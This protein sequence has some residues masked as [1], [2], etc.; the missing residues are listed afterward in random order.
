MEVK[1][2]LELKSSGATYEDIV[3]ELETSDLLQNNNEQSFSVSD[4]MP[5]PIKERINNTKPL[6]DGLYPHEV[7][8]INYAPNCNIKDENYVTYWEYEYGINNK[9]LKEIFNSLIEKN[10]IEVGTIADAMNKSTTS[11]LKGLLKE[12]G[13]KQSGKK[14]DLI[15]RLLENVPEE[16][17]SFVFEKI[18]YVQTSLGKEIIEKYEWVIYIHKNLR[19]VIDIWKFAEMMAE[20]PT[21]DYKENI[22]RY[23]EEKSKNLKENNMYGLY[24]NNIYKMSE[25]AFNDEDYHKG[26]DLLCTVTAYDLSCLG[27]NFTNDI[28]MICSSSDLYYACDPNSLCRIPPALLEQY[29]KYK[30]LFNWSDEELKRN[31]VS[32]ISNV[33]LPIRLYTPEEYGDIVLAEINRDET[34]LRK[35]HSNAE[36]SFKIK[37][38]EI[39]TYIEQLNKEVD[40]DIKSG[41]IKLSDITG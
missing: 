20:Y 29:R 18:P 26:F 4:M 23:I 37:Y 1:R 7:L 24:R 32:N 13:L 28:F 12:N 19:G 3:K 41:R 36:K 6:C 16:K 33:D 40:N 39:F 11:V 2:F 15:N 31:I 17:L 34:E 14:D 9:E 22:W 25:I 30:E 21:Q 5:K 35:I 27:N 10:Y 8:A 38:K